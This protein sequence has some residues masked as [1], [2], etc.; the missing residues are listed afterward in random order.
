MKNGEVNHLRRMGTWWAIAS[1]VLDVVYWFAVGPHITPGRLTEMAKNNQMD[2]NIL[3]LVALPVL[4][5]VWI[6]MGYA[7]VHW[8]E[9]RGAPEPVG[10]PAGAENHR[11]NVLWI[12]I[13]SI[14]V[15]AA[16]VFGT[17]ALIVDHGSGGGEGP[18]PVWIPD[19][20]SSVQ[21]T[22]LA[23]TAKW[24]PGTNAP[25]PVQVIGQQW[26]FTYRYPT[27]GNFETPD[28][29][30]PAN[31]TVVFD[32]TSL[33]VI[34]SFWA[35]QLSV[36]ADANPG[37]N[38][39][40]YTETRGTGNFV[41][42]C[43][44]LCG[45]WHGSM[46]DFGKVVSQGDFMNWAQKTEAA[47]AANTKLLPAFAYTYTPDAN[48]AAGGFYPD[49]GVTPYSPVETYGAKQPVS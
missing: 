26:R 3:F 25:L 48:G 47:N 36:K 1:I 44:E 13:T 17:W 6:F 49:G 11:T 14:A 29:V 4:L 22:A 24:A 20:A 10:G 2:F 28:L 46:F 9:K 27:F 18:N 41:V 12:S 33:D 23:G 37:V 15:L 21:A 40:A 5:G 39:V 19:G 32:V 31:T 45:I 16:A 38:N 34:H 35:Y 8:S 43:N 7:F 42:R 30:L